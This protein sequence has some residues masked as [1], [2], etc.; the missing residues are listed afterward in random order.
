MT[1]LAPS[2]DLLAREFPRRGPGIFLN[3]AAQGILPQRTLRA[4]ADFER[5]REYPNRIDDALLLQ[6]ETTCR[7]RIAAL[8]NA[9]VERIGLTTNTSDGVNVAALHLPLVAGD[10]VLLLE[11]EFPANV[12]PWLALGAVGVETVFLQPPDGHLDAE[13]ISARLDADPRI[14]AVALSL[15]RF[16]SG[17]RYPVEAV[18]RACR[19]RGVYFVVDAMQGLGATPFDCAE[20]PADLITCGGQ[21]WLCAPWGSGFF[22]AAAWLCERVQ[23]RRVGWLQVLRAQTTDYE[24]LCDYDLRFRRDA[25][26]FEVGTYAYT[27]LLG[28]S[29]SLELIAELGVVEIRGHA[30]ALLAPLET[31]LEEQ[32]ATIVSCRRPDCR[33][34]IF[35]FRLDDLDA[36][37]ALHRRL[38]DAGIT[39]ACREGAIRLSPHFYNTADDMAQTMDRIQASWPAAAALQR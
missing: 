8:V 12:Y 37:R 7:A 15:V 4:M 31:F 38:L 36:T 20:I 27:A 17:H 28:L 30:Q 25:T 9:P 6:V 35:C 14:R 22:V 21:K 10:R 23:P 1:S 3:T 11:G 5:L 18:G 33:S 29:E 39:C 16:A 24:A 2:G 13:M 34:A 19:E 26:R 32:G